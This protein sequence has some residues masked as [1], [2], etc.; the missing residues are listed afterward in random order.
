MGA[1]WGGGRSSRQRGQVTETPRLH[2]P[3]C[4]PRGKAL[5]DPASQGEDSHQNRD[6]PA[7]SSWISSLQNTTPLLSHSVTGILLRS[8]SW[9]IRPLVHA[10]FSL[11]SVPAT[12]SL[13]YNFVLEERFGVSL[14]SSY[15]LCCF[16]FW[17]SYSQNP[18]C[19]FVTA[20]MGPSHFSVGSFGPLGLSN[21]HIFLILGCFP[22][23]F[24]VYYLGPTL[25]PTPSLVNMFVLTV[26]LE[27]KND[28]T[29]PV[30]PEFFFFK[31]ATLEIRFY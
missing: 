31:K 4:A 15:G 7:S 3:L 11:C 14:G 27:T 5:E 10:L 18:A 20:T 9:F 2:P 21:F 19:F 28:T 24:Y 16:R 22:L 25:P 12:F 23:L 1:K 29:T 17:T 30:F 8:P 6:V 26:N 13:V